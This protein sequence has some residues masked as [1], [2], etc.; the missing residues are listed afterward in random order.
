MPEIQRVAKSPDLVRGVRRLRLKRNIKN[1]EIEVQRSWY[2]LDEEKLSKLTRD[3]FEE[4][5]CL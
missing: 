4:G 1:S 5:G 3:Y 2:L